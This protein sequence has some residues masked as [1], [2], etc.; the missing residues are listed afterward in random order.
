MW[1]FVDSDG[2]G[3]DGRYYLRP[4]FRL[5]RKSDERYD[6]VWF[7]GDSRAQFSR[8]AAPPR[9]SGPLH[10]AQCG[11]RFRGGS[12][13]AACPQG[14]GILL[15]WNCVRRHC[16]ACH[17]GFEIPPGFPVQEGP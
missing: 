1:W 10:C 17:L 5:R 2:V 16:E 6:V 3:A 12:V 11:E 4:L 13:T 15:H 9:P 7:S 14:C 8:P